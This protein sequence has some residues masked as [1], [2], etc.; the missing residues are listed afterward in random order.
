[1]GETV[2]PVVV[3]L[4]VDWLTATYSDEVKG[5]R[6]ASYAMRLVD[7][8]REEGNVVNRWTMSGYQGW[9]CGHI[10]TGERQDGLIVRLGGCLAHQEWRRFYVLCQN[11]SR[12]DAQVTVRVTGEPSR[13]LSDAYKV[14]RRKVRRGGSTPALSYFHSSDG[15]AT[16]YLGKRS[17]EMFGR[18]YNKEL[19]SGMDHYKGCLRAEVE[20]KGNRALQLSS[21]LHSASR[22]ELTTADIVAG[23]FRSRGLPL[24]YLEKALH[25][26]M[27]SGLEHA[28][29]ILPPPPQRTS[30]HHRALTFARRQFRKMA[31]ELVRSELGPELLDALGLSISATGELVVSSPR[32]GD[33]KEGE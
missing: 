26:S 25:A 33:Q 31:Q 32:D 27:L 29:L 8:Q 28:V 22:P 15:S 5:K 13:A 20:A 7:Q 23:Y 19:E 21:L 30:D 4:G 12:I 1:M 14:G 17:S 2:S 3:D 24:R 16:L 9:S 6:A 11:V 10:Q 18:V